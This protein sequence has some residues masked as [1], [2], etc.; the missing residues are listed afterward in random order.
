MDVSD[1]FDQVDLKS[2]QQHN[3]TNFCFNTDM[4]V[5]TVK[6]LIKWDLYQTFFHHSMVW[7]KCEINASVV[8]S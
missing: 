8:Q 5:E 6:H 2:S 3:T 7:D 1:A 4:A